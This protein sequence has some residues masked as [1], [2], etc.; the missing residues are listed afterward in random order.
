MLKP[1]FQRTFG[2][3]PDL[4][5]PAILERLTDTPLRVS[6]KLVQIEPM[7]FPI[8]ENEKWSIQEHLGHLADI[9]PLWIGRV[10]DIL[11]N[12]TEYLR[13]WDLENKSVVEN[14]YNDMMM[15]EIVELFYERREQFVAK[16]KTVQST[17]LQKVALHPRLKTPMTIAELAFFVAEHDDHHLATI[18]QL[19]PSNDYTP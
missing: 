1:W 10:D 19:D 8:Q 6:H 7:Y 13:S 2:D 3:S 11:N 18:T 17:D 12:E 5:F 15:E 14:G 16:L 9:E 4:I